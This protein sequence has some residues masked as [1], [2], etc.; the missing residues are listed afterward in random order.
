MVPII[1]YKNSSYYYSRPK[2]DQ[3]L[4]IVTSIGYFLVRLVSKFNDALKLYLAEFRCV[5]LDD[6]YQC[7]TYTDALFDLLLIYW[8]LLWSTG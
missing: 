7:L 8:L 3:D 1:S 4:I 2:S 6:V 5:V